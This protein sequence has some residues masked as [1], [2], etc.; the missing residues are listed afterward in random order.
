[1]LDQPVLIKQGKRGRCSLFT[2]V[3]GQAFQVLTQLPGYKM[4]KGRELIFE[5]TEFNIAHIISHFKSIDWT[6]A[7]HIYEEYV[8]NQMRR[9]DVKLLKNQDEEIEDASGY[10]YKTEPFKHQRDGFLISRDA[11]KF[12]LLMEQGT[13]K[14]KVAIDTAAYLQQNGEIEALVVIAPNG[15]HVNWHENELKAHMPSDYRSYCYYS[16]THKKRQKIDFE[17]ACDRDFSGLRVFC[18]NVEAFQNDRSTRSRKMLQDILKWFDCMVVIDESTRIKNFKA[19]RTKYLMKA[20]KDAKYKRILSGT[21]VTNGVENLYSQLKWLGDE[22]CGFGSYYTFR[23]QYCVLGGYQSKVVVGYKNLDKLTQRMDGFSYRVLKE[24]CLDLPPKVY[25]RVYFELSD[26][27]QSVYNRMKRDALMMLGKDQV[28]I[29]DNALTQ[30]L[31][32]HQITFNW[33]PK[34]EGSTEVAE[35]DFHRNPR[36]EALN[37]VIEDLGTERK[38]IIWVKYKEDIKMLKEKLGSRC[39][40][41]YGDTSQE[42]RME[43]I[44]QFQNGKVQFFLA[45]PS[46]AGI[47]LTLTAA[48]VVIYYGNDYDLEKRLQSEDRAHRIDKVRMT[49]RDSILYIDIVCHNTVDEKIIRALLSKKKVSDEILND[50]SGWFE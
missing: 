48:E 26:R 49:G 29:A 31:R 24:D 47:G 7:W 8:A 44:D 42:D 17:R 21:P 9:E 10:E 3:Q 45:T 19:K 28:S 23:N 43:A 13:G 46:A 5:P 1:M 22:I 36:Y 38:G 30:A 40:V 32:L 27:Q 33:R 18:F 39:V 4:W 20:C 35:I 11:R 14:T 16:S 15:V 25:Q 50:P 37:S 6:D 41:Y 12:A 2:N 34:E